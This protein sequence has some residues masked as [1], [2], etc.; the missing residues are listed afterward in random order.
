MF[1]GEQRPI[2]IGFGGSVTTFSSGEQNSAHSQMNQSE[3]KTVSQ[4]NVSGGREFSSQQKAGGKMNF[5]YSQKMPF[6]KEEKN[7]NIALKDAMINSNDKKSIPSS[8]SFS[9]NASFNSNKSP[10]NV[11]NLKE[12]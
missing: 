10:S 12:R 11:V 1:A 3:N 9:N 4:K 8:K 7:K 6:E 2:R 5:V